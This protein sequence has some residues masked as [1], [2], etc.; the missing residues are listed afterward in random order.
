MSAVERVG[1]GE[2]EPAQGISPSWLSGPLL[3][4]AHTCCCSDDDDDDDDADDLGRVPRKQCKVNTW[5]RP[6]W[7]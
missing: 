6:S 2:G 4:G 5:C 3:E 7:S 1:V